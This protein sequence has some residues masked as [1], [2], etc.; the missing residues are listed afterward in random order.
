[1]DTR[2]KAKPGKDEI[3]RIV[4]KGAS[5]EETERAVRVHVV[6]PPDLLRRIDAALAAGSQRAATAPPNR[7]L[8]FREAALQR[9]EREE[10]DGQAR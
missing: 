1:M 6:V 5:V 3:A 7:S 10:G 4:G 8:W 2:P 9:L